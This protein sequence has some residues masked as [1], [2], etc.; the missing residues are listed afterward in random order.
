MLRE[1]L[2]KSFHTL[3][4]A[5]WLIMGGGLIEPRLPSARLATCLTSFFGEGVEH[6]T[7]FSVQYNEFSKCP[8]GD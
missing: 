3:D 6:F 8:C 4:N 2:N 5:P 1:I 7:A